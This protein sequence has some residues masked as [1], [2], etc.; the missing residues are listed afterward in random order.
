MPRKTVITSYNIRSYQIDG[1]D[2]TQNPMTHFFK[3][4]K[5]GSVNREIS[6]KDYMNEQYKI[7]L[8]EL[9]QPLLF[10]NF[11]D[12]RI[13]LPTELCRD[14]SL[15]ENFTSDARKMRDLQE[16]KI[17]HPAQRFNRIISVINKLMEAG[18][19]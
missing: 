6:M 11:R 13:Y 12:T 9:K 19:F 7:N 1:L 8:R 17:S 14:A 10:V 5:E 18:E 16:F 3:L 15:P 4:K 2:W